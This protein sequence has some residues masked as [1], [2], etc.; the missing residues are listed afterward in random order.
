MDFPLQI[1]EISLAAVARF[2]VAA[3]RLKLAG[4]LLRQ[5]PW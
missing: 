5:S 3:G 1:R 2:R 4:R